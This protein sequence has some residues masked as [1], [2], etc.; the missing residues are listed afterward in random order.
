MSEIEYKHLPYQNFDELLD[1]KGK[2]AI[3][4]GGANG[5][6]LAISKRFAEAGANVVMASLAEE[7]S[8]ELIE[9]GYPAI[10]VQTNVTKEEDVD[11]LINTAAEKFGSIDILV[12]GAGVYP[13][14]AIHDVDEKLWDFVFSI[15]LKAYFF[16]A[17]KVTKYMIDNDIKGSVVNISSI[18][19]H[20]PMG[21]HVTY[22]STKGGVLAMTRN[23]AYMLT[24]D[25][26]RVNSISPGLTATPGNLEPELFKQLQEAGTLDHIPMGRAGEPYEI[27][28]AVLF[29]SSPMAGFI[30]GTDIMVDGGWSLYGI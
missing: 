28:N 7:N 1:L 19:G 24:K 27:A 3:V 15:N 25:G 16:I 21:N 5:I 2:T 23:M 8:S 6:G 26:V 10:F 17:Q 20:R 11:N 13:L 4:T 14:K 12:N 18:C 30:T 29:L 22:D 9:A